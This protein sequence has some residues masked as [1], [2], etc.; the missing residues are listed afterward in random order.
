M[1]ISFQC[2]IRNIVM[3]LN[4]FSKPHICYEKKIFINENIISRIY[5]DYFNFR[6]KIHTSSKN[7]H[8]SLNKFFLSKKIYYLL[9]IISLIIWIISGFYTIQETDIGVITR[10][11]KFHHIVEPGL[12]W[13]LKF[14]DMVHTVNVKTIRELAASGIMLTSDENVV[15]VEMNVQYRVINPRKYLF[16]VVNPDD[17]LRQATDSA[18]RGVIGK[19]SMD[20]ILTEGRTIIRSDTHLELEQTIN[21]YD[22]GIS[23]LDVNFQTA[24]APEEVKASF[25]DAISAR[26]NEQQ[27]IREAEAYSNEV[28]PQAN[29]QAQR[30]IENA[31]AYKTRSILQA[32]GEVIQFTQILSQYKISPQVTKERL[33]IETMEHII[34]NTYNFILNDNLPH[35]GIISFPQLFNTQLYSE[36]NLLSMK[37]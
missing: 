5:N 24:R 15:H 21:P 29:G 11:G 4:K 23:I 27:Y 2:I 6:W 26:E 30:I 7:G 33:Y 12:N 31:Y 13:K 9:I 25:D 19:Y 32:Q 22:M 28:Q 3:F 10:F 1:W 36:K 17:S 18:L 35:G 14:I 34:N 37:N 20:T 8:N 16:S